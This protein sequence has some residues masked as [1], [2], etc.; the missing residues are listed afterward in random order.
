VTQINPTRFNG[1]NTLKR[2]AGLSLR[3]RK[4]KSV[5]PAT[6]PTRAKNRKQ[7]CIE[8][9]NNSKILST[10]AGLPNTIIEIVISE[11][12]CRTLKVSHAVL[13]SREKQKTDK[14][15]RCAVA[16]GSAK[17]D[18]ANLKPQAAWQDSAYQR[19]LQNPKRPKRCRLPDQMTDAVWKAHNHNQV[20]SRAGQRAPH[21][22]E[23]SY[24]LLAIISPGKTPND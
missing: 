23:T 6:S 2:P 11:L 14:H 22:A 19:Q 13:A 8:H 3:L 12:K 7:S 5:T 18:S 17:S 24:S 4:P 9:T 15:R 20:S 16:S 21:R 1:C 10:V